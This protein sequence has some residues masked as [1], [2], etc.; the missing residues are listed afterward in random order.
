MFDF[1][2]TIYIERRLRL[3]DYLDNEVNFW[4]NRASKTCVLG[5]VEFL[6]PELRPLTPTDFRDHFGFL[7]SQCELLLADCN[8]A[9]DVALAIRQTI[10]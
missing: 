5:A 6:W 8:K 3:A 10:E 9:G 2:T 1:N 4:N 7:D